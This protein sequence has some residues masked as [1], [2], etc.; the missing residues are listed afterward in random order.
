MSDVDGEPSGIAFQE[1]GSPDVQD[2][3]NDA[4]CE[5]ACYFNAKFICVVAEFDAEHCFCTVPNA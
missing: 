1:H 3:V 4:A 5:S 2:V